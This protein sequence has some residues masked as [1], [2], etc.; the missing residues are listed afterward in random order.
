[1]NSALYV[2]MSTSTGQSFLQLLQAMHRSRASRTASLRHRSGSASPSSISQRRRARPRVE[3]RS[4]CVAWYVGHIAPPESRRHLPTPTH[5][6]RRSAS[7]PPSAGKPKIVRG[8]ASGSAGRRFAS[9]GSGSTTLPGFMRLRRIPDRLELAER[10]HQLRPEH[11][12]QQLGSRLAVAVLAGERTAVTDDQVGRLLDERAEGAQPLGRP[13]VELGAEVQAAVAEMAVEGPLEAETGDQRVQL[14]QVRAQALGRD[15]R[16]L[17][18]GIG[19]RLARDDRGCAHRRLAQGP[20]RLLPSRVDDHARS[21]RVRTVRPPARAFASASR[22]VSPPNS[23]SSQPPPFGRPPIAG[24]FKRLAPAGLDQAIV[25]PL[26]SDRAGGHDLGRSIGRLEDVVEAKHQQGPAGRAGHEPNRRLQDR[27]ARALGADERTG[28]V[29]A[30]LRQQR[31]Q[32]EAGD[33]PRQ[34]REALADQLL[35][36]IPEGAEGAV[37]VA[38]RARL[39]AEPCQLVVRG[40][41]DRQT[42]P[43]VGEHVER[44]DVVARA[45]GHDR[46]GAA[47]V[48]AEHPAQG[49]AVVRGRVGPEGQAVAFGGGAQVVQDHARL[50]RGRSAA[51]GPAP[52]SGSGG[53]RRRPPRP[54]WSPGRPGW[55]RR[56][57]A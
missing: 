4:S 16:V 14:A 54:R 51:P 32:G 2:A 25:E 18:A 15:G 48:V 22:G 8:S 35:V 24:R 26:Q 42:Q 29:E 55:C 28:N 27:D 41:A 39:R 37:D 30:V 44:L 20:H 21:G 31:R 23:T 7:E 13:E 56:R 17:P 50:R 11:A 46:V 45:A 3:W 49:A 6:A 12:R 33:Q 34:L 19:R 1:M 57:G 9:S 43:V 5:R 53:A 38:P 36:P 40:P 10:G 47:G 52:R